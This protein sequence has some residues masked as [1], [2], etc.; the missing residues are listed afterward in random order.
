[1]PEISREE[2]AHL[3]TLARIDLDDAELDHLAPQLSV[4]LESVASI[5]GVAG[6]DV[7]P[8]SHALP[9]TN[10]FRED[11]VVPGLTAEEALSGAPASRAAALQRAADPGGRAVSTDIRQTAAA[12]AEAL[13]AGETTSVELTRLHLDRIAAV[14]GAVHAFLHVDA[15]GALAQAA[16][17]DARRAAGRAAAARSTACR[18]PSR[19]CS[20]PGPAHDLRL[21]DPRGLDPAVRR[22]RRREAQGRRPAD[23]GQDQH[24]RVRDGLLHRALGVRPD[25]QP[26]GPR[27]DPRRLR[28]RLGGGGRRLRGAARHRHRH[29]R[30][31][32]PARRRHRHGRRQ[33]DVRRGVPLRPRRAGQ[34]PRPGRPGH[35]HGAGR[36]AAARGHRRPRPAR[37]HLASTSRGRRSPRPPARARPAT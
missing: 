11:V 13:A 22:D 25:A 36:R 16:E 4:I 17:S 10:V 32:P 28:R 14:D 15:E 23:P 29:R 35:P 5:N 26:V 37:L 8:T 6:D 1:M 3:A 2:V 31:D 30:L 34:Q 12:L 24:G 18:S 21:E 33:A 9:L 7:P 19:T 20:P 27:P